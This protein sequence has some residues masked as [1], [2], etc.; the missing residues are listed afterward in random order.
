[1]NNLKE[2]RK[3]AKFSRKELEE[4]SGVSAEVIKKYE[5][6]S[7]DIKKAQLN[8]LIAICRVLGCKVKDLFNEKEKAL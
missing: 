8:N 5:D 3:K 6:E 1:M 4:K 2:L 7:L